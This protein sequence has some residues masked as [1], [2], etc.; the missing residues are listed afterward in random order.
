MCLCKRPRCVGEQLRIKLSYALLDR[1]LAVLVYTEVDIDYG[2]SATPLAPF[3]FSVVTFSTLGYGDIVPRT[4][5]AQAVV[6]SEVIVGYVMLGGLLTLLAGKMS[7][8]SG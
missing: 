3:Y 8:S 4:S 5:I 7:R 6:I 1:H 2:D